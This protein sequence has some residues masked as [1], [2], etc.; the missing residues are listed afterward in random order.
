MGCKSHGMLRF[1]RFPTCQ[2]YDRGGPWTG[3]PCD[4][5]IVGIV[6]LV[7]TGVKKY[8]CEKH[9]QYIE[10]GTVCE[11]MLGLT[12]KE[13]TKVAKKWGWEDD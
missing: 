4:K 2:F 9:F 8:V 1:E 10:E 12:D 3:D 11:A 7:G 5:P 13:K 6:Y